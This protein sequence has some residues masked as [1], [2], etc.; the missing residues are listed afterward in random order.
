MADLSI[1]QCATLACL[2]E[3]SAP[4]PGNVHRGADFDD[5]T[6]YDFQSVAVV[7]G[8]VL[9]AAG[10]QGVGETILQAVSAARGVCQTN[11]NLGIILLLTPL[12]AVPP[13][14]PLASGVA[15]VLSNLDHRDCV[16]VYEAIRLAHPAGLGQADDMDVQQPPPDD[17]F[18]AMRAAASRD[19][20][21]RQYANHFQDVLQD[22]GPCLRDRYATSRSLAEAIVYAHVWTM[23]RWPDSLIARKCGNETAQQ[24]AIRAARVLAAEEQGH[25]NYLQGLADFDFWLRTDGHRRNPGTTA[26]LIAAGLFSLLRDGRL[27]FPVRF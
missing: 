20:V 3:A 1:A 22:I 21:A 16:C 17:L 14:Q 26:D 24:S 13:E 6:L 27:E 2:W 18:S 15:E 7:T 25:D 8:S 23:S 4:K 19:S 9:A 12:A 5:L 10:R 11:V